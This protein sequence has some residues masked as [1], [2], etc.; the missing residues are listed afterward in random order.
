MAHWYLALLLGALQLASP[1]QMPMKPGALSGLMRRH[2][3]SIEQKFD[4][5]GQAIPL[6]KRLIGISAYDEARAGASAAG[7]V[8]AVRFMGQRCPHCKR[9]GIRWNKMIRE[10]QEESI[11]V[12]FFDVEMMESKDTVRAVK[13]ETGDGLDALPWII[14]YDD[15]G[16]GRHSFACGSSKTGELKQKLLDTVHDV[17]TEAST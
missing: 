17:A 2:S 6:S 13:E 15:K 16:K 14:I 11:G 4:A 1:F 7:E 8:M 9:M 12:R 5:N 3:I 10:F